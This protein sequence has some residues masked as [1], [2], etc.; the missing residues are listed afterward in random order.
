VVEPPRRF[1]RRLKW[2]IALF[3]AGSFWVALVGPT[4]GCSW[5]QSK[6]EIATLQSVDLAVNAYKMWLHDHEGRCPAELQ[7]LTA[8]ANKKEIGDPWGSS[9][10]MRCGPGVTFGVMSA[11]PDGWVGTDDDI[12]SWD[13]R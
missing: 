13:V 1:A 10:M 9:Y 11:G 12:R 8:Y 3:F 5:R 2:G 4:P 7:E 6:A